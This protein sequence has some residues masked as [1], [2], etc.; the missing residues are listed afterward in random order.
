MLR[1][2]FRRQACELA[3]GAMPR[4]RILC[5]ASLN[6][7]VLP[8]FAW[9]ERTALKTWA[10][11]GRVVA[12]AAVTQYL[13]YRRCTASGESLEESFDR[14]LDSVYLHNMLGDSWGKTKHSGRWAVCSYM[15]NLSATEA[16]LSIGIPR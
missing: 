3:V 6:W 9:A 5:H 8:A 2:S 15:G 10:S 13:V 1:S 7:D 4:A 16:H 14:A 12:V 11:S